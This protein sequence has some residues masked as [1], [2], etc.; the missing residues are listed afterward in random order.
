MNFQSLIRIYYLVKLLNKAV[1]E[2][3]THCA[4]KYKKAMTNEIDLGKIEPK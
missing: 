4:E 1:S 3:I 2:D